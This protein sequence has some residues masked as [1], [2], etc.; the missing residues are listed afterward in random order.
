MSLNNYP[1]NES[2]H[3]NIYYHNWLHNLDLNASLS[4]EDYP[5][6]H[7]FTFVGQLHL[8]NP[9]RSIN[10]YLWNIHDIIHIDDTEYNMRQDIIYM[11]VCDNKI[12]RIKGYDSSLKNLIHSIHLGHFIPPRLE[13][14]TQEF[15]EGTTH[16]HE[17]MYN[18]IYHYLTRNH[19]F[20]LYYCVAE[21]V[22]I[23]RNI[24]GTIHNIRTPLLREYEEMAIGKYMTL[25]G[26]VPDLNPDFNL[27]YN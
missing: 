3:Q 16:D 15:T 1:N 13:N 14:N 11:F 2:N 22:Y 24:L 12:I 27:S 25:R 5:L 10:N 17:I 6:H 23:A 8:Q 21:P 9:V 4:I 18:T 26:K 19:R 20:D 7:Y